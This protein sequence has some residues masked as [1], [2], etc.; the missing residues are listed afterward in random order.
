MHLVT[1]R[2]AR[3]TKVVYCKLHFPGLKEAV[4]NY[5]MIAM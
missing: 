4:L 5:V 3:R 1:L 2:F